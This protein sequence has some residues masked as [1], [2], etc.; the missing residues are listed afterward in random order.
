MVEGSPSGD[1]AGVEACGTGTAPDGGV[2]GSEGWTGWTSCFKE[3]SLRAFYIMRSMALWRL[4]SS[5]ARAEAEL[6]ALVEVADFL[7]RLVETGCEIPATSVSCKPCLEALTGWV[8]AILN[9]A[10]VN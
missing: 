9:E 7:L 4:S 1:K 5:L 8:V 3:A 2:A 6:A 10:E